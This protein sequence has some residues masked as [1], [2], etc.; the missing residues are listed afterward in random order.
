VAANCQIL[1]VRWAV[2]GWVA[3]TLS[4]GCLR[5]GYEA[6]TRDRGAH[7]AGREDA[8]AREIDAAV[9]GSADSGSGGSGA[10]DAASGGSDARDAGMD[11]R[12][13]AEAGVSDAGGAPWSM[14]GGMDAAVSDAAADGAAVDADATDAAISDAGTA[15]WVGSGVLCPP[16]A[17]FCDGYEDSD[18]SK[19]WDYAYLMGGTVDQSTS[20]VH[21]GAGALH[22]ETGAGHVGS[23]TTNAARWGK[24]LVYD[25]RKSGDVWAR[26]Y[27]YVPSSTSVTTFFSAGVIAEREQPYFGFALIIRPSQVDIGVGTTFYPGSVAFP[28]DRWVCVEL[29][30]AVAAAPSGVFELYLDGVRQIQVTD[31]NTLPDMGYSSLD[32]GIHYTEPNQ[33]AV[34]AYADDV[35]AG[36]TRI[37]CV[38]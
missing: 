10:M 1:S 12:I 36:T 8:S 21:S 30:A 16:D 25:H 18:F 33:G 9:G 24:G 28:R 26:W 32:I 20:I 14:D 38:P 5:F 29:H 27:Y 34:E 7:D 11:A 3:L 23:S 4:T 17:V 31:V 37:G 13:P 22:A 2:F 15:A 6:H 19:T 35:A